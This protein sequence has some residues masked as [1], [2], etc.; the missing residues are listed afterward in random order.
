[1]IVIKNG[2]IYTM[3]GAVMEESS[4]LVKD[5]KIQD[6]GK[7]LDIP[8]EATVIDAK[9]K[10]VFPG[11]I[12][13]HCHLGTFNAGVGAMGE[14]VN[15]KTE[16]LTPHLRGIDGINPMDETF[17]TAIKSG[18]TTV[19]T[20]PG[21]AN[22]VGGTFVAM[23][24]WGHRVDDMILK[25]AIAMKCAFGEN[26]KR[27]YGNQ[28]KQ[29]STRMGT[30]GLLRELLFQTLEYVEKKE[31]A[32]QK[33]DKP[34]FNMKLEAM[35]P[36]VKKEIPLKAHA[37]Q[38]DDIFTAIRIAKEFKLDLTLDHCTEGHLIA[39]DLA[40][41]GFPA[42]VGPTYTWKS[43]VEVR[44]KTFETPNAL[45]RA[46][47]KVAI[48]TDAPVVPIEGLIFSAAMAHKAGLP[49]A[50]ALKCIS[51]NPAEILGIQERVGSLEIGKDGDIV[52]WDGHPF[53]MM[54]SPE[55]TIVNGEIV[56]RR[57]RAEE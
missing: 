21:S 17:D 4:I 22:V 10:L 37:H 54:A 8:K 38:A 48:M 14:D 55:C 20:G 24:T 29:P 32:E 19:A 26:P 30:A 15:E 47:M 42:I 18:I 53:D 11:F 43:K 49:E 57:N 1:M 9:G 16:P 23:K 2:T 5:G 6:I 51:I 39:E 27:F 52:I 34:P 12:D 31:K 13:A 56:Y 35:I 7:S 44:N 46:G 45:Y 50:E 28:G 41:E 40:K 33:G 3:A 36:V 25:D